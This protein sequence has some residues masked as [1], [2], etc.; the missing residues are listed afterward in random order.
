MLAQGAFHLLHQQATSHRRLAVTHDRDQRCTAATDWSKQ[1]KVL[2]ATGID[3][4][5][6]IAKLDDKLIDLRHMTLLGLLRI[7]N[8]GGTAR[9]AKR[10]VMDT[11]PIETL[12]P[13]LLTKGVCG[14]GAVKVIGSDF[15]DRAV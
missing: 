8:Q 2:L 11:K 7:M 10:R 14:M 12:H 13:K 9:L 6:I 1:L 5:V 3:D 4:Q 15:D